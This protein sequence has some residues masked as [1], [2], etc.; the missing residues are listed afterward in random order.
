MRI[1]TTDCCLIRKG[2]GIVMTQEQSNQN[3]CQ[4]LIY[5]VQDFLARHS[6]S[7][8]SEKDLQMQEEPSFSRLPG[9]LKL[10]DPSILSLKMFP[11]CFRMTRGGHFAP[12]SVRFLNWGTMSNGKCLT[13]RI[14]ESPQARKRV[15]IVGYF[16][17]R[18]AGKVLP[19]P[20]TNGAALV[21]VR[22]GSQGK[23]VY[24][25]KGLSCTLTSQAGGMG[26]KTG[27]YDVGVPIKENTKLGYKLAREGDSIDLGYANLNSRRGRV[28][29]QIAH[30]L[31]TGVQQ[32]TLHFVDLSPPPVVTEECR[33]L[34][35]RQ[36]GVHKYKG[37]CSGVL[38]EDGARAVLTP[39][40]EN[41]RQN[42]RRM[43]EP[44]EPMF[45]ITATD[46]HGILYHGRIRRLVPRECL[47]L[48]G[49]YDWQIDKIIDSTSDAQLYKQAG[50][51]VTVNVIEAIGRLLQKADSELNTQKVSEKGIH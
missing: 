36:C 2:S 24:S 27:L 28:G 31:T 35:T 5:S 42:G 45:T 37:E 19:E 10:K 44:E 18:C 17:F 22:A 48:Q 30:T 13:A 6:L 39:A 8:E 38:A 15:Y 34:N 26:G 29:H 32:G 4:I 16:D 14:S 21:Q 7:P 49:Y 41:V 1:R 12:S 33:S 11:V 9:F 25:P 46:R 50:N 47:R 40:K 51:G 3:E 20:E 23:R 43:K